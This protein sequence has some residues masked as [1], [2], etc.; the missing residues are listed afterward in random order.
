MHAHTDPS[1]GRALRVLLI[2]DSQSD[3]ELA[4]WRLKQAGYTCTF[5][6]VVN[7]VEMRAALRAELPDLILSDFSLPA[8]DGMSALAIARAEAPGVPFIFL[9]GTIGEERA[10][11]ALKCGAIDYVL[12]S[13]PKRLVP[14][15]ERA[16]QEAQL[17]RTSQ[18]AERQVARLTR[19]LQMLS[20]INSALVR[21]QNR[22]EVMAETCRLA[23]GVGGYTIA[24]LALINPTTR[25][26]RPVGWA[27]YEFL[28]R[29]EQE[30]PVADHE[31]GDTSLMGRVI[32]TGE[33]VL[34]PDLVSFPHVIHGRDKLIAAGVR[35]LACLPL[36]VDNT[37][38]G[39]FLCG[40]GGSTVIGQDE[41]LLLEEVA[42]NLSFA[43][44]Y[45]DKQDAVHFLSYFEPLTGLAK[46]A[47]FCERLSRLLMRGTDSLPRLEVT[48]FDITHLSVI[49]DS[50]GRHTG[51]RLLQCVADRLKA[52]FPD[53]EQL[54]H[55]GGGTFACV[56][57]SRERADAEIRTLHEDVARVFARPFSVDGREIVAEIKSG[58]AC[59]PDDGREANELVQNAEAAL[60][61]AKTSGER[62]LH[63]RIEMN[64]EL[65][66]RVGLEQ[67]LRTA[68][69]EGQFLLHYQPKITLHT[70]RIASVEAL[71]RWHDPENGL[72]SPAV[73]LP[74]LESAGLMA[75]TG[76]WVFRQAASDCR[77]W[78]CK[79]LPP[80]RVAVNISPPELRQ[81]NIA[82]EILE[83]IGD[84]A[85]DPA[86]GIDIEITEGALSGDSSSCVHALRLLR[87]AGIRIA[88]DDFGTGFS[89][90]GRLS[91]LPID[92][93]KIDRLF[94]SR[95]PADRRSCTLVSTIIGLA[96]A[97]DMTTVAEGV[98]TQTQLDY[99]VREGCDESQ[100]YL[101]SR[102]LPRADLESWLIG[103][104]S[105]ATGGSD[106]RSARG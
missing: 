28:P 94:T 103:V 100:G 69:D 102:P 90:L 101:H 32:R 7:E 35:S 31:T 18:A 1:S 65:A 82:G 89:S 26:A 9:S 80:I 40:T 93:L 45:L 57:A 4:M 81:R 36:R 85:G 92:T 78:R 10:I 59:Y 75:A 56:N 60:K 20:G 11:E 55:L 74:L 37:P 86:W 30:F 38:V 61:E 27:G 24:M 47:L 48:V 99:L 68:L 72:T 8:F 76:A 91:E 33:A 84:L 64:S 79:G 23:H 62:Y 66:R 16:L 2:E 54:A 83:A 73:F 3:A 13:N 12:K 63:H 95:L 25:M 105:A 34:C 44:Q 106:L 19:V 87:A 39:S 96:H 22:D 49:N 97:F 42:A 17:R 51:D 98:E 52:H 5:R 14:A 6:C 88:I 67:R 70:G 41:L 46:R 53:T 15:V 104:G 43:L 71:L 21:I 77:A 29:P 50:F 58:L